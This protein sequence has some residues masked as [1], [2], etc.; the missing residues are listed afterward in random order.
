MEILTKEA[1]YFHKKAFLDRIRSGDVFVY[2]TDTIYGI[3]CLASN[4]DSVKKIRKIKN[5]EGKPFSIIA[6]SKE[7]I[8][9]NCEISQM[10]TQWMDKLPGPY[11][12][13]LKLKDAT[14]MPDAVIGTLDTLGVRIPNHWISEI[15]S[16]LKET[17]I[18]TSVNTSGQSPI[19]EISQIEQ[20]KQ[21]HIN[22]AIDEQALTGSPSQIIILTTNTLEIR[23]R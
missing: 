6:P 20:D 4:S 17:I 22:F 19:T 1:F 10:A 8:V 15:A 11:T 18:T 7:W 16:E 14:C 13:V 3:G 12:L 23:K 21:K 9:A 2:P 5:R